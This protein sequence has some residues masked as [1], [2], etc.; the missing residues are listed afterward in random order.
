M[1][2]THGTRVAYR[3]AAEA[4]VKEWLRLGEPAVQHKARTPR[5]P[6]ALDALHAMG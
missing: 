3:L 5:I 1:I 6:L 4:A 2:S